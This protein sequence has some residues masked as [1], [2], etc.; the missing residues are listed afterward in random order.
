MCAVGIVLTA[1]GCALQARSEPLGFM[2]A[3]YMQDTVWCV[4]DGMLFMLAQWD[5]SHADQLERYDLSKWASPELHPSVVPELVA[6]DPICLLHA[7]S[8]GWPC[9]LETWASL[10][11]DPALCPSWW[12]ARQLACVGVSRGL[13]CEVEPLC[14]CKARVLQ[15]GGSTGC[16]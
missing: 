9:E 2:G 15:R 10:L 13:L 4:K 14:V 3:N 16:R 7:V 5:L 1:A 12:Q 11:L 6:G 8:R